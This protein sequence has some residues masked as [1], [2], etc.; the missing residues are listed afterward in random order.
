MRHVRTIDCAF[1]CCAALFVL[2][3]AFSLLVLLALQSPA[4]QRAINCRVIDGVSCD[5]DHASRVTYGHITGLYPLAFTVHDVFVRTRDGS[6]LAYVT[7]ARVDLRPSAYLIGRGLVADE[8]SADTVLVSETWLR[9]A[10]APAPAG[11]AS[12]E[13]VAPGAAATQPT[14]P[15]LELDAA[16]TVHLLSVARVRLVSESAVHARQL[17]APS[18]HTELAMFGNLTALRDWNVRLRAYPADETSVSGDYVQVV[19][20]GRAASAAVETR[21]DWTVTVGAHRLSGS[22]FAYTPWRTA[23]LLPVPYELLDADPAHV[24]IYATI[25]ALAAPRVHVATGRFSA[26]LDAHRRVRIVSARA[27]LDAANALELSGDLGQ[28]D[29]PQHWPHALTLTGAAY[30]TNAS[31]ACTSAGAPLEC[32]GAFNSVAGTLRFVPATHADD[33]PA[34]DIEVGGARVHVSAAGMP[35]T[36]EPLLGWLRA[37]AAANALW[38]VRADSPAWGTLDATLVPAE[39]ALRSLA[40]TLTPPRADGAGALCPDCAWRSLQLSGQGSEVRASVR[41]LT[42]RALALDA[43]ELSFDVAELGLDASWNLRTLAGTGQFTGRTGAARARFAYTVSVEDQGQGERLLA[44]RTNDVYVDAG[45]REIVA[46]GDRA[47]ALVCEFASADMISDIERAC[48]VVGSLDVLSG[49]DSD[50]QPWIAAAYIPTVGYRALM[51]ENAAAVLALAHA[52]AAA[53]PDSVVARLLAELPG[54]E[55]EGDIVLNASAPALG[56]PAFASMSLRDASVHM[57]GVAWAAIDALDAN[58]EWP[59]GV[60]TVLARHASDGQI[61]ARGT[62]TVSPRGATVDVDSS[63]AHRDGCIDSVT[64]RLARAWPTT[65]V[66]GKLTG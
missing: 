10:P 1:T 55:L 65:A 60:Y 26:S 56:P 33:V 19:S 57:P 44:A 9:P 40:G 21:A 38:T 2:F 11:D 15:W 32:R 22:A 13:R 64:A 17:T 23:T 7:S 14:P 66:H 8:L 37:R 16:V 35:S 30:G 25:T 62:A 36:A 3:I 58:A 6:P 18:A 27:A 46:T 24:T 31:A 4:A 41:G 34:L 51:F 61:S 12:P 28:L 5:V 50:V 52:Y 45:V 54:L 29:T 48:S 43:A 20:S 39:R 59:S 42:W 53:S 49:A 47:P 63:W